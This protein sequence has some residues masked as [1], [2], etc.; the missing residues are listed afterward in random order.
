MVN[1]VLRALEE[2]KPFVFG[3]L[4]VQPEGEESWRLEP[5]RQGGELRELP[6]D[7]DTL[8][9]IVRFDRWGRYRPLTGARTLPRGWFVRAPNRRLLEEL[10][11]AVYPLGLVH[12][13]QHRRGELRVVPLD[14]VLARQSGRYAVCRE[15]SPEGRALVREL[16]CG[17]CVRVPVWAGEDPQEQIPCPEACSVFV[18]FAR[19]AALWEQGAGTSDE[20]PSEE[21]PGWAEFEHPGNEL[22]QAFLRRLG[23][24]SAKGVQP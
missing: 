3:E 7:P 8:R 12:L 23:A 22:R 13:R 4:L 5:A 6:P 24:S 1:E 10:L 20:S 17:S 11:E 19:E 2:R 14:E 16:L 18:A 15:L 21:E 9:Q